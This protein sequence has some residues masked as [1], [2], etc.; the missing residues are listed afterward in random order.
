LSLIERGRG[1]FALVFSKTVSSTI[2]GACFSDYSITFKSMPL[3]GLAL[4]YRGGI[5]GTNPKTNRYGIAVRIKPLG[6]C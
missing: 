5:G 6:M 1:L 3:F 4:R 2:A